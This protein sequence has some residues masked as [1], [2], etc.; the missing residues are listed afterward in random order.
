MRMW[1]TN[2]QASAE[3]ME[4]SQSLASR[5]DRP[6]QA[7]VRST[8]QLRGGTSNPWRYRIVL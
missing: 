1:A 6:S 2:I 4:F 3:A 8:T 5:R 7:K